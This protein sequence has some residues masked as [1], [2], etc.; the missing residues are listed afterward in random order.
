MMGYRIKELEKDK[1]EMFA[2]SK[3]EKESDQKRFQDLLEQ[4]KEVK[5]RRLKM[6]AAWT[7]YFIFYFR[8]LLMFLAKESNFSE[9]EKGR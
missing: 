7:H 3:I 4:I 9:E 8:S 5:N 2:K 6:S 1:R